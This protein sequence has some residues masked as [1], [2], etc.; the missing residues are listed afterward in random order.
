MYFIGGE[1]TCPPSRNEKR[2]KTET[3]RDIEIERQREI[4]LPT[5]LILQ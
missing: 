1:I 2:E 3:E 4:H 5:H